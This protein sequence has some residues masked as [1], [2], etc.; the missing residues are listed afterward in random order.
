MK[1]CVKQ[2]QGV[3]S[4]RK[5]NNKFK[6]DNEFNLIMK[7]VAGIYIKEHATELPDYLTK[8]VIK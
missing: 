4:I 5:W 1:I 3:L 2:N 7:E 8:M 6:K